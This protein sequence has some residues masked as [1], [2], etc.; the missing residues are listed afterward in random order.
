MGAPG[1][2]AP[3]SNVV[4]EHAAVPRK[5]AR[6]RHS[7]PLSA[8]APAAH[9]EK[10]RSPSMRPLSEASEPRSTPIS[11]RALASS[12]PD[13]ARWPPRSV[14]HDRGMLVDG[15][16]SSA[17]VFVRCLM[18]VRRSRSGVHDQRVRR[19]WLL[20]AADRAC[21]LRVVRGRQRCLPRLASA[22]GFIFVRYLMV[23]FYVFRL[24]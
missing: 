1:D 16:R 3:T 23:D 12:T 11:G 17:S 7:P 21:R 15:G 22:W 5:I 8:G 4:G 14:R 19:G 9:C 13:T 18:E 10:G 6:T 24:S 2:V 20:L